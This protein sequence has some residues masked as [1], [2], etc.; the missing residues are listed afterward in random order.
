MNYD[1]ITKA[2]EA[3]LALNNAE[4]L[5]FQKQI[6]PRKI[7]YDDLT[8]IYRTEQRTKNPSEVRKD[9]YLVI[10][11]TL[12][13]LREE[14]KQEFAKDQFSSQAKLASD[15]LAKFEGKAK[16]ML[17]FRMEKIMKMAIRSAMG[18]AVDISRLTDE[19]VDAFNWTAEML[20]KRPIKQMGVE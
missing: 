16:Y 19:E 7:G 15:H 1:K 12:R 8:V 2:S 14:A 18:D 9:L 3:Y 11:H 20:K 17:G 13:G 4:Q 5:E 6:A 10:R